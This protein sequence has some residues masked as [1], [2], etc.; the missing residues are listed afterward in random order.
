MFSSFFESNIVQAFVNG[1]YQEKLTKVI[2]ERKRSSLYS[3]YSRRQANVVGKNLRQCSENILKIKK[4]WSQSRFNCA[5]G[6]RI[7]EIQNLWNFSFKLYLF[8]SS[9]WNFPRLGFG[10]GKSKIYS[11]RM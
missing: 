6:I 10:P 3:I 9:Q 4:S 2:N 11:I 5:L 8:Q 1:A 7:F